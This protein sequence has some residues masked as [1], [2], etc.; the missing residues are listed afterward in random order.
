MCMY[1][2][3]YLSIPVLTFSL[4]NG[5]QKLL[6]GVTNFPIH[7][8]IKELLFNLKYILITFA[9]KNLLLCLRISHNDGHSLAI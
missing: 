6:I 3:E 7:K 2:F 5:L 9:I 4:L 1:I 8:P